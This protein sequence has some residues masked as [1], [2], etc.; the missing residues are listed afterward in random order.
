[1][2]I[3]FVIISNGKKVDKTTIVLKSIVYQNIPRYEILLCGIYDLSKIPLRCEAN[4]KYI[5]NKEAADD[6]LLGEMRNDGCKA[7][8][9]DNIV[10]LDDD[11]V[12]STGWYKSYMPQSRIS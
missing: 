11:M 3:S 1:M 5:K 4:L 6:G 12:L 2:D 8:K 9:H 7:A 10:I